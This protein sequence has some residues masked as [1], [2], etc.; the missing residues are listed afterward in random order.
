MEG[1]NQKNNISGRYQYLEGF[2]DEF[3][4]S[5]SEK[6]FFLQK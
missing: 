5:R 1:P 6:P 4:L 2:E 3:R